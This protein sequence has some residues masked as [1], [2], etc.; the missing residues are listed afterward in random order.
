MDSKHRYQFSEESKDT[1]NTRNKKREYEEYL[2]QDT[3]QR[4]EN[5]PKRARD[6]NPAAA[7]VTQVPQ[8]ASRPV[9]VPTPETYQNAVKDS[10]ILGPPKKANKK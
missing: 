8:G 5:R 2:R 7:L 1:T 6:D 3:K 10:I 9:V 4:E